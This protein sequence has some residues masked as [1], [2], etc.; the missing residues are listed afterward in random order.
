M[1]D[2]ARLHRDLNILMQ[3]G[4]TSIGK[5]MVNSHEDWTYTAIFNTLS[6]EYCKML[7]EIFRLNQCKIDEIC[8]VDKIYFNRNNYHWWVRFKN[9]PADIELRNIESGVF[10]AQIKNV[11][12]QLKREAITNV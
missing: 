7:L 2:T 3:N 12:N 10:N 8:T 1:T 11:M 5:G 6:R 9:F 4:V